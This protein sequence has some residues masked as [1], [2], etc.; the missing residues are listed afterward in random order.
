MMTKFDDNQKSERELK[1]NIEP[2]LIRTA[3]TLKKPTAN[4]TTKILLL[5]N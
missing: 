4:K 2:F 1:Y 5:N 3:E